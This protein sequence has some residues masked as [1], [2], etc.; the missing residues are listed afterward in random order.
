M[1]IEH[2]GSFVEFEFKELINIQGRH[3]V[4][5][6]IK[7]LSGGFAGEINSVWFS[8]EDIE[9]FIKKLEQFDKNRQGSAELLNMSSG[10]STN[11]LEF[12]VFAT[13]SLGHLAIRAT[14][15]KLIY[16]KDSYEISNVS[17]AFEIDPSS[18]PSIIRDFKKLFM[19]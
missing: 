16:F 4:G 1:R 7:V 17:V 19:V 9:S 12:K 6:Q 18:L 3:D 2:Q 13:D 15:Q 10:T 14:L 11:P 8:G 5:C